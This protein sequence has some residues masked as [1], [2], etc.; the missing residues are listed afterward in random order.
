M[1]HNHFTYINP[2]YSQYVSVSFQVGP[3]PAATTKCLALACTATAA[4]PD[5]TTDGHQLHSTHMI[6]ASLKSLRIVEEGGTTEQ[7]GPDPA[8]QQF[9]F[10]LGNSYTTNDIDLKRVSSSINH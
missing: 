8:E 6:A 2:C 3:V 7:R 10:L 9:L 5:L 1:F 4:S